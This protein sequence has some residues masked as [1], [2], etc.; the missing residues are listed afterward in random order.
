[1]YIQIPH[2]KS[3]HSST[4]IPTLEYVVLQRENGLGEQFSERSG[5]IVPKAHQGK[6][7]ILYKLAL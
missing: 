4:N 6:V 3:F 2:E 1:M 7:L 5:H